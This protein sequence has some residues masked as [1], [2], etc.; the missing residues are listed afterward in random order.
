MSSPAEK[1]QHHRDPISLPAPISC[2]IDIRT[3]QFPWDQRSHLIRSL[4]YRSIP[5]LCTEERIG[6]PFCHQRHVDSVYCNQ[7]HHLQHQHQ[8][9][10]KEVS[11]HCNGRY[12]YL[13]SRISESS[14]FSFLL[15][16]VFSWYRRIY[17]IDLGD[18][19]AHH[20]LP[21]LLSMSSYSVVGFAQAAIPN[22]SH[23]M[24]SDRIRGLIRS[25]IRRSERKR[26][27]NFWLAAA[28]STFSFPLRRLSLLLLLLFVLF[29]KIVPSPPDP[30][31]YFSSSAIS[32]S[33]AC[34]RLP[35]SSF[36]ASSS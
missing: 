20:L 33:T 25:S 21:P 13:E 32:S 28:F 29:R 23:S 7:H 9:R 4:P 11:F 30:S 16:Q 18:S 34:F 26:H 22:V 1:V 5:R 35:S 10:E 3:M 17:P 19:W 12:R 31:S 8:H 6:G 27:S 14:T 36:S 2:S 15:V 24:S